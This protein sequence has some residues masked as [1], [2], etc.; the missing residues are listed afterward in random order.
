[1]TV[2]IPPCRSQA[3]RILVEHDPDPG[4]KFNNPSLLNIDSENQIEECDAIKF[5]EFSSF[6]NQKLPFVST[7]LLVSEV[8]KVKTLS[9]NLNSRE[10][11][12]AKRSNSIAKIGQTEMCAPFT[13][14]KFPEEYLWRPLLFS[15]S[16]KLIYFLKFKEGNKGI[17]LFYPI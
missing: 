8:E 15:F 3:S 12:S 11:L 6:I 17:N 4:K 1:M 14:R 7:P 13:E 10:L 16:Q 9:G 5:F 2:K